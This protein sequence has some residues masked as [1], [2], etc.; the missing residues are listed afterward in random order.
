MRQLKLQMQV[1]INGYV[2]GPS[3]KNDWM[4]W[5]PTNL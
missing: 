2:A 4:T 5:N 3:E 1:T